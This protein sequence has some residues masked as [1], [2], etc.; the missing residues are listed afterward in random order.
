MTQK[1]HF[2]SSPHVSWLCPPKQ[3]VCQTWLCNIYRYPDSYHHA[4][5]PLS[6][7]DKTLILNPETAKHTSQRVGYLPLCIN[8]E[9]SYFLWFQ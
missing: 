8:D 9:I 4:E 2:S 6:S 1:G 3:M 7:T 5:P